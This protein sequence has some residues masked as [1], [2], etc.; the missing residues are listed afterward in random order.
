MNKERKIKAGVDKEFQNFEGLIRN[1][2]F[3]K[4][5]IRNLPQIH[6]WHNMLGYILI[7]R[8]EI[9][10]TWY[11]GTYILGSIVQLTK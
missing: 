8:Q 7:K 11:N 10:Y 5:L 1:L 2:N 9:S 3:F 4:G 6:R